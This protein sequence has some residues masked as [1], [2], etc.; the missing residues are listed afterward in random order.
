MRKTPRGTSVVVEREVNGRRFR[1]ID[2]MSPDEE[3]VAGFIRPLVEGLQRP[4]LLDTP[5]QDSVGKGK[6]ALAK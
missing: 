1:E 4:F 3:D 5:I 2:F 6:G